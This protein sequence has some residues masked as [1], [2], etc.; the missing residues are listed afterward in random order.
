MIE[1]AFFYAAGLGTR[2]RPLTEDR[3]KPLIELAGKTLLEH[4]IDPARAA[5]ITKFATNIHYLADQIKEHPATRNFVIFDERE[6]LL[7]TGGG[8]KAATAIL[9]V[10]PLFTMN[11]DAVWKGENPFQKLDKHWEHSK[12]D[13]LLLLVPTSKARGYSG[14]GDFE[15]GGNG[16]IRRGNGFV[17]TG[18]QIIDPSG[19]S[20]F[21]DSVFSTN[22]YWDRLAQKGRLFGLVYDGL[23]CDVGKPDS[24]AIAE[25]MLKEATD[26]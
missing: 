19:L 4:A 18:C 6:K 12:M 21:E 25:N 16:E 22:L 14:K 10:A 9:G 26:V 13:A 11:T 7:E 3:P 24:I 2:M 23:W 8:L 5:G 20:D 17:Y 1:T 15:L